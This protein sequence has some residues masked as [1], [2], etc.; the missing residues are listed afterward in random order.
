MKVKPKEY[1]KDF[2]EDEEDE[3]ETEK[4]MDG[5]KDEEIK[6]RRSKVKEPQYLE[7]EITLSLL[8]DKLN[9]IISKL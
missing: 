4:N 1:D 9:F 8:N 5:T 3:E 7:R 6:E 2:D